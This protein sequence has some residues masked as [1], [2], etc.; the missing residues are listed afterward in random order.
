MYRMAKPL[1]FLLTFF[2]LSLLPL[3][4][5]T[6]ISEQLNFKD[7][8]PDCHGL[9]THDGDY[10]VGRTLFIRNDT[11]GF[12]IRNLAEPTLFRLEEVRFLGSS[13]ESLQSLSGTRL[14]I[15]GNASLQSQP[16]EELPMPLN[17]LL[18]SSTAIPFESR[19]VYRN[20][21]LFANEVDVQVGKHLVVGAG[22][23]VPALLMGKVKGQISVSE[24]LHMGLAVQ[25]FVILVD[26]FSITHPYAIVTLGKSN[27]YLNF[28]AG[29]WLER[30]NFGT[31][32]TESYPMVTLAGSFSFAKNWR[33]FV[34]AAAVFQTLD[35]LV[36]PTF[37]FSNH[38][39]KSTFEFGLMAI[40]DTVVPL[41]PL[42]TYRRVF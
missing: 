10:F 11:I 8:A 36:L 9:Y 39:R 34:E 26:E 4:A 27:Q 25:Q 28:T 5:Q 42:L 20:T 17:Q 3:N 21:M 40:P 29:Y 37:N 18:Y 14:A 22:A 16:K 6:I 41:L 23:L 7:T 1:A 15:D 13:K 30:E 33:F 2:M 32:S 19:G 35:N 12:L 38:R 24:M 31:P